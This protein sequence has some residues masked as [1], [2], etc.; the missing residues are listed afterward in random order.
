MKI[1]NGEIQMG[2]DGIVYGSINVPGTVH[3]LADAVE[4]TQAVEGIVGDKPAPFLIDVRHLVFIDSQAIA[5][6]ISPAHARFIKAH[7]LIVDDAA[8]RIMSRFFTEIYKPPF[9]IKIFTNQSQAQDWL[10][11]FLN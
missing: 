11:G 1:R 3:S 6:F 5:H 2:D 4:I 7:A 8:S 10:R 9:P